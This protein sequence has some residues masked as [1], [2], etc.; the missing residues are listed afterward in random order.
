MTGSGIVS[1]LEAES[2]ALDA[3]ETPAATP[4]A[5][6]ADDL[7]NHDQDTAAI[8]TPDESSSN[9]V[10]EADDTRVCLTSSNVRLLR[11]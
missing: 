8:I 5:P 3:A 10:I 11:C 9:S 4:Y 1:R 6:V 2:I 7:A